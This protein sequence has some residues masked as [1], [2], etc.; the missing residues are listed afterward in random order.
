VDDEL[1][2]LAKRQIANEFGLPSEQAVRLQGE[3]ATAIRHDAQLMRR[4]LGMEPLEEA[5]ARDQQGR[6]VGRS[7]ATADMNAWLRAASGR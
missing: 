5:A 7:T 4:E 6:F 1:I 3:S 2:Q